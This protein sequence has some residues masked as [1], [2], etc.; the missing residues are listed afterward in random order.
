MSKNKRVLYL[1]IDRRASQGRPGFYAFGHNIR[2]GQDRWACDISQPA[3]KLTRDAIKKANSPLMDGL[4]EKCSSPAQVPCQWA[5]RP[6]RRSRLDFV[7]PGLRSTRKVLGLQEPPRRQAGQRGTDIRV[8]KTFSIWR[9]P[10]VPWWFIN[11]V[12]PE[13]QLFV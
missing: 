11:P 7:S 10:L 6:E 13:R 1:V 4:I 5:S 3:A 2:S 8:G 9:E 12:L